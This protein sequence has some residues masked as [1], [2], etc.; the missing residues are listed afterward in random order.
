M[1]EWTE[2]QSVSMCPVKDKTCLLLFSHSCE[3]TIGRRTLQCYL[4]VVWTHACRLQRTHSPYQLTGVGFRPK[5]LKI[6]T[7][8]L[9]IPNFFLEYTTFSSFCSLPLSASK[10]FATLAFQESSMVIMLQEISLRKMPKTL[11]FPS[12]LSTSRC[13]QYKL[14]TVL[15]SQ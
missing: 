4:I 5:V 3:P 10:S 11:P 2:I 9:K 12:S 15:Y 8:L 7:V 1:S 14:C 13:Q 6:K